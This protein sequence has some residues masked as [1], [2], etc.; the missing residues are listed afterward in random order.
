MKIKQP[1][2][3]TMEES[4]DNKD[5]T[6]DNQAPPAGGTPGTLEHRAHPHAQNPPTRAQWQRLYRAANAFYELAPWKW[7]DDD[8]IFGVQCPETG[9]IHYCCVLGA[10]KEVFALIAYEGTEGLEGYLKVLSGE[11]TI[12]PM[13]SEYQ[14]CLEASFNDRSYL[15]PRDLAVIRELGLKYRG[16]K[17]WP[18]FRHHMPGF[19]PWH[20]SAVQ[21]GTLATC[22][23]QA[24]DVLP[25]YA[26][27]RQLLTE[28]DTERHFVRVLEASSDGEAKWL[29]KMLAPAPLKQKTPADIP[30][31]EIGIAR[32]RRS[33]K[34]KSGDWEIGYAYAPTCIQEHRDERPY[35]ARMLAL[36]DVQSGFMLS[37]ELEAP[38]VHLKEFRETL[39]SCLEEASQWPRSFLVS[40]ENAAVLAAPIAEALGIT[41]KQVDELPI[42]SM[43]YEDLAKSMRG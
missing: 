42:F 10:M 32:L 5:K 24:I 41:L 16:R 2:L 11:V 7:V 1:F 9:K 4:A 21:A 35:M 22:L 36:V 37:L 34:K 8:R 27:N 17:A 19:F 43:I 33:P 28:P 3:P 6:K 23:E 29:D 39:L 26:G 14:L 15:A 25:R 31:N 40:H 13:I 20:L 18:L 30:I 12:G 38:E